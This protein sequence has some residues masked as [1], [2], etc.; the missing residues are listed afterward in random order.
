MV[1]HLV[2]GDP[3]ARALAGAGIGPTVIP[4]CDALHEGPVRCI[5]DDA[6]ARLRA[7]FFAAA[8]WGS[9][10]QALAFLAE[11]DR[12]LRDALA[13]PVEI[14]LWFAPG[15]DDQLRRLQVLSRAARAAGRAATLSEARLD[16]QACLL[17]A[18]ALHAAFAGRRAVDAS[19]IGRA[20]E[21]WLA[22]AGDDPRRL[23]VLLQGDDAGATDLDA[24]MRRWREEFPA[25]QG[26]LSRSERQVLEALERGV[27]RLRDVHAAACRHA[28]DAGFLS[29]RAFASL[30]C[31]LSTGPQALLSHPDQRPVTMPD[32]P[33]GS[34]VFWNDALLITRAGRERLG[35]TGD[36]MAQAPSRCMGGVV[37][38]G[39]SGWRW[40]AVCNR[41]RFMPAR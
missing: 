4:W 2:S 6:L 33:T 3:A 18:A 7:G 14:V 22:F 20:V 39:E 16:R 10:T 24:A 29:D 12:R 1:V 13:A 35:G 11:R 36:W 32:L 19:L 17:D 8:G 40:D 37:L 41:M 25:L 26:G 30:L 28:E 15:L 31:R 23:D 27:F 34:S 21:G 5:A 38:Q 9:E